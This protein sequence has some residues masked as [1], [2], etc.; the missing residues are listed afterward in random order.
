MQIQW[1]IN[2]KKKN[3]NNIKNIS[4]F[5]LIVFL[6]VLHQLLM[7]IPNCKVNYSIFMLSLTLKKWCDLQL[8]ISLSCNIIWNGCFLLQHVDCAR[9]SVIHNAFS[10][11][12]YFLSKNWHL[13]VA[14]GVQILQMC[15]CCLSCARFCCCTW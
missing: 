3:N 6:L 9:S 13:I 10:Q 1:S 11:R 2:K 15:L 7:H 14:H 12:W 4:F 5:I 8:I